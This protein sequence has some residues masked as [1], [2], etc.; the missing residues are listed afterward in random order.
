MRPYRGTAADGNA[1]PG[2]DVHGGADLASPPDSRL[3]GAA[4][5]PLHGSHRQAHIWH[6]SPP[7]LHMHDAPAPVCTWRCTATRPT[8]ISELL[9]SPPPT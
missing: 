3:V 9:R 8:G 5:Q 7:C 1:D 6:V 4:L 2:P